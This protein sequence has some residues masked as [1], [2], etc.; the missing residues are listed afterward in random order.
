MEGW[1]APF[2]NSFEAEEV[3]RVIDEKKNADNGVILLSIAPSVS[4][5]LLII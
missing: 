4:C 2:T 3:E 1:S 5:I